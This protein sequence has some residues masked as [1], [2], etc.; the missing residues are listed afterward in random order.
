[1]SSLTPQ[2]HEEGSTVQASYVVVK[3]VAVALQA[4]CKQLTDLSQLLS[5][6]SDKRLNEPEIIQEY[7]K[8]LK[9]TTE[10]LTSVLQSIENNAGSQPPT[11]EVQKVATRIVQDAL[12][13]LRLQVN[14]I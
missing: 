9:I 11:D 3:K 8:Q 10:H 7:G 4:A 13:K 1:M 2:F 5:N 14:N 12:N 6:S